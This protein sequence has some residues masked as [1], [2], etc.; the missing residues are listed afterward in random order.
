MADLERGLDPMVAASMGPRSED[1]GDGLDL[2]WASRK[3]IRASMGPRS[4]D[5]GD[6][7][8]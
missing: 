4:E 1:R 2:L 7:R 5:R 3:P 8:W 6:G